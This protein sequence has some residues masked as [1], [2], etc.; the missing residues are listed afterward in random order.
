ML[1]EPSGFRTDWAGRSAN[2]AKQA[3]ADYGSTAGLRREQIRARSGRQPG[4]PVRAAAAILD[5]VAAPEPP[6]RLLLGKAALA[7]GRGKIEALKRDF[8]TWAAVSEAA[9]FPTS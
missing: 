8:E 4:D 1:V 9:D 7:A 3:I 6:L 2:E 5:A